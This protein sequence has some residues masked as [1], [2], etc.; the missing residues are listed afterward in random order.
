M[1]NQYDYS[2]RFFDRFYRP[3]YCILLVVGDAKPDEVFAMAKKRY[4]AW[5]RGAW[6]TTVE[7]EPAQRGERR[8]EVSWP[9]A[10]ETHLY[11]GYHAPGFSLAS[12]DLPA[13][14]IVSELL[15]SEAAPLYQKLVVDQ[16]VVDILAGGV[17]DHRD[18][19]LFTWVARV[20][21]DSDAARV[22]SEITTALAA[23]TR[24]LVPEE[25]LMRVRSHLKSA[26][27][28]R[29]DTP[30]ATAEVLARFLSLAGDPEAV[31][32]VYAMYDTITAEQTREV[33]RRTFAPEARTI[34]TLRHGT[35]AGPAGT[36]G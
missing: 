5:K 30:A 32:R 34:A 3:E 13:L 8:V 15:F 12:P 6:K 33:A 9:V 31:N 18:P 21:K 29:L 25:R 14:D 4:G 11:A 22:E 19:Y 10:T 17:E 24:D 26:F 2:R 7:T 20:K 16:Q 1:P 28:M 23:L 35:G 27:A 36:G